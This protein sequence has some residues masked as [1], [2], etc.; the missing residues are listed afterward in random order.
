MGNFQIFF[1]SLLE[2]TGSL[3]VLGWSGSMQLDLLTWELEGMWGTNTHPEIWLLGYSVWVCNPFSTMCPLCG[4]ATPLFSGWKSQK[5]QH[6][7][8]KESREEKKAYKCFEPTEKQQKVSIGT[9]LIKTR[10]L[11]NLQSMMWQGKEATS[12]GSSLARALIKLLAHI[13]TLGGVFGGGT[14]FFLECA[15]GTV[16]TQGSLFLLVWQ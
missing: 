1:F 15:G 12:Q 13:L 9:T 4:V 3:K 5:W 16:I 8:R 10:P 6:V 14:C 7:S 11:A 2:N